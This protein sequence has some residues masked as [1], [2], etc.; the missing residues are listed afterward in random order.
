MQSSTTIGVPGDSRDVDV[1][2]RDR[3]PAE[4]IDHIVNTHHAYTRAALAHLTPL[5]AKVTDKHGA[6]HPEL[7]CVTAAFE[8]LAQD[9]E[10]HMMKEERVLFP[11]IRALASP[12]G[13]P[14]PFF[15]TIRNPVRLMMHEH[16]RAAELFA[17]ISAATSDFSPPPDACASF[18][19]LYAGLSELRLDLMNHV[20]LENDVLFPAAIALEE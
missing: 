5:L 15:G 10:P 17:E 9:M 6:H 11:Y 13:T 2:W 18:R 14:R 8:E 7:A 19:A 16:D 3:P 1:E 20:S 12:A 4:L